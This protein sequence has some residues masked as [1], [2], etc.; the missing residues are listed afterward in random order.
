MRKV[1]LRNVDTGIDNPDA[2]TWCMWPRSS[3][4]TVFVSPDNSCSP[5]DAQQT[6]SARS[7]RGVQAPRPS[8]PRKAYARRKAGRRRYAATLGH[9]VERGHALPPPRLA[10]DP[11]P[12]LLRP[13]VL[14]RAND[15]VYLAEG[16]RPRTAAA[17]DGD[18]A[19]PNCTTL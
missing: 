13:S 9:R 11:R 1:N 7:R 5:P 16:I 8:P 19:V 10:Q 17:L 14:Q 15:L 18:G 2:S 3:L 6:F 12:R 4:L